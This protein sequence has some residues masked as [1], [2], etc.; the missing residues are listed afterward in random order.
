VINK[1]HVAMLISES[2]AAEKSAKQENARHFTWGK[3]CFLCQFTDSGLDDDFFGMMIFRV[4]LTCGEFPQIGFK[5]D[6]L[7]PNE[8]PVSLGGAGG[9]DDSGF[10]VTN[11]PCEA[12]RTGWGG[13]LDA[14]N[15]HVGVG[16]EGGA[17]KRR[18]TIS[19]WDGLMEGHERLLGAWF[20]R[21]RFSIV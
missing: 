10:A 19:V 4:D 13:H 8:D 14:M 15:L 3:P 11:G 17:L 21:E 12:L 2:R 6:S 18:P 9:D 5:R 7:L 20:R 1:Q 16:E